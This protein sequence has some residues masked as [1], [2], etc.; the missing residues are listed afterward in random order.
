MLP[1]PAPSVWISTVGTLI[2]SRSISPSLVRRTS[3]LYERQ[4]SKLVPPMST[5]IVFRWP[6]RLARMTPPMTPAAGPDST[7]APGYRPPIRRW[8]SRRSTA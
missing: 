6:A 4:T 3:P 8:S 1:P 5:E 2:G 7:C